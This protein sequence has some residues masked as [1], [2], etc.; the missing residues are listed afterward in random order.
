MQKVPIG[1]RGHVYLNQQELEHVPR[2]IENPHTGAWSRKKTCYL[3]KMVMC[4]SVVMPGI[5]LRINGHRCHTCIRWADVRLDKCLSVEPPFATL[6]SLIGNWPLLLAI[7]PY[8]FKLDSTNGTKRG[9]P[10]IRSFLPHPFG[11][12]TQPRRSPS[13]PF[14]HVTSLLALLCVPIPPYSSP[15]P[16]FSLLAYAA[17]LP[18]V[19]LC[20]FCSDLLAPC[21]LST[22]AILFIPIPSPL[23]PSPP[24]PS[25]SFADNP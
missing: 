19:L 8:F 20:H 18:P 14:E 7:Q 21:Q 11:P 9:H 24:P 15:P 10:F 5:A 4:L 23:P 13:T 25:P 3:P 12:L 22:R 6:L 2:T 1:V 17:P 16:P